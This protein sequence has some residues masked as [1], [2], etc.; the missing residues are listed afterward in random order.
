VKNARPSD[1]AFFTFN[2]YTDAAGGVNPEGLP[3]LRLT[4][5]IV[6]LESTIGPNA[7]LGVRLPF[8][9][10]DGDPASELREIGDLTVTGKYALYNDLATGDVFTLG[11][12]VTLPTGGRGP[13]LLADGTAPPRVA[14]FQPWAG[15]VWTSGD[16]FLQTLAA[17]VL[18]GDAVYPTAAFA[19]V[20]G[21]YWVYRNENDALVRGIAPVAELHFNVPLTNRS[22][23]A[24]M[25][26]DEQVNL[27]TGV[28]FQLPK[29]SVGAAVCV[30]LAGP[31]P[32]D[33]EALLSVNY[34]F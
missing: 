31:K 14:F 34:Q 26:F 29:M 1:R 18:P 15:G 2:R 21:G 20:G 10:L 7:S 3:E 4:R 23:G 13:G 5:Q 12:S 17:V 8:L 28:N 9:Q 19:S 6:G 33:V 11:M 24:L 16:S 22:D 27:T 32:Y 30:P 25:A